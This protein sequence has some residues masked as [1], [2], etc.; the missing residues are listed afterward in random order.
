MI[1]PS[2]GIAA[3]ISTTALDEKSTL[4]CGQLRNDADNHA[5]AAKTANDASFQDAASRS[6]T[7]VPPRNKLRSADDGYS[8]A[9]AQLS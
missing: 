9:P 1:V 3:V 8:I 5:S 4:I 2:D 7:P 6:I